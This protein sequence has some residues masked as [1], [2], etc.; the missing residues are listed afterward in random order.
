LIWRS[1]PIGVAPTESRVIGN[2][3]AASR[4]QRSDK[5]TKDHFYPIR[6]A[7]FIVDFKSDLHHFVSLAV[8]PRQL[9]TSLSNS[10]VAP[11]PLMLYALKSTRLSL[12]V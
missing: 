9:G 4:D 11:P 10:E 6:D 3:I 2:S 1:R 8:R 7:F 12:R 5:A